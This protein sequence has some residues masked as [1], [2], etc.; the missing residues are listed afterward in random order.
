MNAK[1]YLIVTPVSSFKISAKESPSLHLVQS[2]KFVPY[3]LQLEIF[4]D[5][6]DVLSTQK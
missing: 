5:S 4:P 2:F 6:D 3:S 1:Q